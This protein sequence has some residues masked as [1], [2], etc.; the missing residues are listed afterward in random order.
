MVIVVE[1]LAGFATALPVQT[2]GD[3][4][5]VASTLPGFLSRAA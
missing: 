1:A 3:S 2:G 4:F 5:A